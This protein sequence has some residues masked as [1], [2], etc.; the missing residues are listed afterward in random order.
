MSGAASDNDTKAGLAE[1]TRDELELEKTGLAIRDDSSGELD[2]IHDHLEFPTEDEMKSLRRVP[3]SIPLRTYCML[4]SRSLILLAES[5]C[6]VIAICEMAERFS[7]YGCTIVFVSIMLNAHQLQLCDSQKM[8]CS[9]DE[10]HSATASEGFNDWSRPRAA[11][12]SWPRSARFHWPD[13][14]QLILVR[15][16][17]V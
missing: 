2:G 15:I 1:A 8:P 17:L 7:Y 3:D 14:V 9:P 10:L 11:W 5:C 6:L 13:Y 16:H 12:C 4:H